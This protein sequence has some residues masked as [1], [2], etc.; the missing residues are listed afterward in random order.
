MG[1]LVLNTTT[2]LM[3]VPEGAGIKLHDGRVG[4]VEENMAD[5]QW[6]SVAFDDGEVELV[7]SQ[8]IAE[9]YEPE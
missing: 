1:K 4:K 8:D 5:G 9:V 7:H 6:L 3:K 2:D